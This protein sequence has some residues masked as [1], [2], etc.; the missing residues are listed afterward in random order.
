MV[1]F[2]WYHK[3]N[4]ANALDILTTRTMPYELLF[5]RDSF[6]SELLLLGVKSLFKSWICIPFDFND[7]T[8]GLYELPEGIRSPNEVLLRRGGWVVHAGVVALDK[9]PTFFSLN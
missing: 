8:T 1:M 2:P 5:S 7:L 6:L 4:F 3:P 9:M